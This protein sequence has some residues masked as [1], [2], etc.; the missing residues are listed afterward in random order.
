MFDLVTVGDIKLNAFVLIEDANVQCSVKDAE[1][2]LCLDYGAKIPVEQV[3]FQ[4]AGS[5]PNVAIGLARMKFRTSVISVMGADQTYATAIDVLKRERVSTTHIKKVQGEMSAYSVVLNFKGEKTILASHLHHV[6]QFPSSIKTKWLYISEMGG[7]Y[8]TLYKHIIAYAKADGTIIA[9]NPGSV[10]IKERKPILFKLLKQL[11]ILFVNVE[12]AHALTGGMTGELHHV[13]TALR[14]L[15]PK[16]VV[17]TDGRNGAYSF[18][19]NTFAHCPIFPGERV[20]ATGAG[21]AFATGYIGAV[22]SGHDTREALRWGAVNSASVVG[23]IGGQFG[24]LSR[25]QIQHR[26]KKA[27]HFCVV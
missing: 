26:L 1:C 18:D 9:M 2:V 24:L 21:D 11:S 12:E 17:I 20:E 23:H 3:D 16:T 15:G 6:Y 19:G 25:T 8:E 10:Q 7:G 4:M 13:A 27:P 22:M 5:A 14:R